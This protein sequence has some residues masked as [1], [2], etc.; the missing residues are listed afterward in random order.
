MN[1]QAIIDRTVRAIN[2]LP[3]DKATEIS[4]FAEFVMRRFEESILTEQIQQISSNAHAF[5]LLKEEEDLYSMD[6]LKE[7]YNGQR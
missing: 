2:Q 1:R 6:D 5:D 4:E 3:V 7:V